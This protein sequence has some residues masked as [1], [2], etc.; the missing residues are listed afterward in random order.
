MTTLKR[1]VT[2]KLEIGADDMK[3]LRA[4]FEH[5]LY[6]TELGSTTV[7]SGGYGWGGSWSA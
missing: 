7:T 1:A 3:E 5:V 2:I 6:C 4:A